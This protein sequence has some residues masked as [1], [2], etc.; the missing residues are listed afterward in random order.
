MLKRRWKKS[1]RNLKVPPKEQVVKRQKEKEGLREQECGI[2]TTY[3]Q[4]QE[5]VEDIENKI[6][7]VK[8]KARKKK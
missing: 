4:R 2:Q 1:N 8:Y 7:R 6:Q 5:V 3:G